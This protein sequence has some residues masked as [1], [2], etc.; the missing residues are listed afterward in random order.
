[1]LDSVSISVSSM[2]SRSATDNHNSSS[3]WYNQVVL[4]S[5]NTHNFTSAAQT[6]MPL[7]HTSTRLY[8]RMQTPFCQ[9]TV[10]L[11]NTAVKEFG[12]SGPKLLLRLP[13]TS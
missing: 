11:L 6:P 5:H 9:T 3:S 12:L 1:M 7:T 8:S 2:D 13:T 4:Q 10:H